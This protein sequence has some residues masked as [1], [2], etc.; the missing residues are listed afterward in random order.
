M[1]TVSPDFSPSFGRWVRRRRQALD[2]TQAQ[3]AAR[4]ACSVALIRKVEGDE[5]RLS[6]ESAELLAD[7]LGVPPA[8]WPAFVQAAR[9]DP[10]TRKVPAPTAEERSPSHAGA[11]STPTP[12]ATNLPT[13][14]TPLIGREAEVAALLDLLYRP[15]CRLLT[16][17]G[18]GGMGKTRLALAMAT[19]A[20]PTFVDGVYV[21]ALAPLRDGQLIV[22]AIA[23]A[24]GVTLPGTGD[25][26]DHLR[27]HLQ[28]R[29][30]LLVLDNAEHLLDD[31]ALVV[32][33]LLQTNAVKV[34]LTSRERLNVH[35]EWIFD[36]QGL[37]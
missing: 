27:Q 37:T 16:L 17:V 12:T 20:R 11:P 3:L 21:V 24:L 10:A 19:E 9:S 30:L 14:T 25:L 7:A 15:A 6:K 31:V 26:L 22:P 4:A 29:A 36:V 35:R 23:D 28:A 32:E 1:T 5:R 13:V 2:L 18:V 8:D 33:R 34:V